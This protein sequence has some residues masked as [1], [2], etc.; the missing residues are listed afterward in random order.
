MYTNENKRI[1]F[2][3]CNQK[4]LV[5]L[6]NVLNEIDDKAFLTITDV[7]EVYSRG[8]TEPKFETER[9]D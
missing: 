4:E 2:V 6:Q 5:I 3:V 7:K 1:L 9:I 8:F